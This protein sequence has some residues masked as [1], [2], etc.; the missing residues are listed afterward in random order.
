MSAR[1]LPRDPK[2]TGDDSSL[3]SPFKQQ[4]LSSSHK[5]QPKKP[6]SG[7]KNNNI[8]ESLPV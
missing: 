1:M 3:M 2:K 5:D 6:F 8:S 4:Q 7:D